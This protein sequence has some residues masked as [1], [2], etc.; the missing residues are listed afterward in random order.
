MYHAYYKLALVELTRRAGGRMTVEIDKSLHDKELPS[1]RHTA[2]LRPD[3]TRA[4]HFD[5]LEKK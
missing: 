4:M 5:I 3:G 2:V 1:L